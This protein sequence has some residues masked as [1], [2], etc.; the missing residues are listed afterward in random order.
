[1]KA[2]SLSI[3]MREWDRLN[4]PSDAASYADAVAALEAE[5]EQMRQSMARLT[6]PGIERAPWFYAPCPNCGAIEGMGLTTPCFNGERMPGHTSVW[7]AHCEH[8]GPPVPKNKLDSKQSDRAATKAWN[9]EFASAFAELKRL[10][11]EAILANE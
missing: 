9:A 10:R 11:L 4:L 7:C 1:M 3:Q 2:E 5:M 6:A 8:F